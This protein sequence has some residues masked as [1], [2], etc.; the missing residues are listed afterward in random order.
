MTR[1]RNGIA[2]LL[3]VSAF[4]AARADDYVFRDADRPAYENSVSVDELETMQGN[5]KLVLL[6]VRLRE[7]FNADPVLIPGASYRDPENIGS[8]FAEIPADADVVVYCERGKWVSQKAANFLDSK[9]IEV[10]SLEGGIEAWKEKAG[11]D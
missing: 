11:Q 6:D 2:V 3:L 4:V 5:P 10:H 9:G 8:W 7:D 1:T